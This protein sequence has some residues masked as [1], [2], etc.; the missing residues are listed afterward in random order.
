MVCPIAFFY[1]FCDKVTQIFLAG[2]LVE[3]EGAGPFVYN[4]ERRARTSI[5]PCIGAAKHGEVHI[6]NYM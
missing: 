5:S 1:Y 4:I 3:T 6:F 2:P